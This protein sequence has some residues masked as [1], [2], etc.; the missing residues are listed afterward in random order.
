MTL[1]RHAVLIHLARNGFRMR[2][3]MSRKGDKILVVLYAH[4]ANLQS[5]AESE[6]FMKKLNFELTDLL[7]L[8]PVDVNLR[9]LRLNPRLWRPSEYAEELK[10]DPEFDYLRKAITTSIQRI[11]FKRLS[12][13]AYSAF[14]PEIFN[15]MTADFV[16]D[17]GP[18]ISE[19]KAYYEYLVYVE[20]Q[21][22][23][24]RALMRF[25]DDDALILN[26]IKTVEELEIRRKINDM[27]NRETLGM[28][29]SP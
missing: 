23:E 6:G 8:E 16:E 19:W 2:Q 26:R 12:R 25:S 24:I 13:E 28:G 21:I 14:N 15:E 18:T 5:V 29:L 1:V 4:E 22:E 9:P 17:R 11:N 20:S 7:S 3:L 27:M 10:N